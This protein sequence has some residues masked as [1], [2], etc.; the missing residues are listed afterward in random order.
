MVG[1][2]G[3]AQREA[4]AGGEA[5]VAEAVAFAKPLRGKQALRGAARLI[6]ALREVCCY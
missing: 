4:L 2:L 1:D 3:E 5:L 6:S